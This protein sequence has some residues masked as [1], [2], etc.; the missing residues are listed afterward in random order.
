[1]MQRQ[2]GHTAVLIEKRSHMSRAQS[3]ATSNRTAGSTRMMQQVKQERF[4]IRQSKYTGL[5][6]ILYGVYMCR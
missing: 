3:A 2:K 6:T 1:M 5:I 4:D